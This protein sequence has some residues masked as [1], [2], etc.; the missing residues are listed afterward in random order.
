MTTLLTV[1]AE[2][3]PRLHTGIAA[4]AFVVALFAGYASGI[5]KDLCTNAVAGEL[6]LQAELMPAWPIEWFPSVSAT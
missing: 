5:W 3:V 4:S 6:A 1:H 2:L